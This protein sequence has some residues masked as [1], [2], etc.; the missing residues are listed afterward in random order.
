MG[1]RFLL[2]PLGTSQGYFFILEF[3]QMV[4][5]TLPISGEALEKRLNSENLSFIKIENLLF[6]IQ[7]HVAINM[8]KTGIDYGSSPENGLR[9][10]L[11]RIHRV[12]SKIILMEVS[13][14][15]TNFQRMPLYIFFSGIPNL[16]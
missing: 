12:F 8:L 6:T 9:A 1:I 11:R 7:I 2:M 16:Q 13:S 15:L 4:G 14:I 3:S 10:R 5:I